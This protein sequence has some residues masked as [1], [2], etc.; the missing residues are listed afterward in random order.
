MGFFIGC[1]IVLKQ[2]DQYVLV[3]EVRG[4]KAGLYNLPAGT[5][6]LHEDFIECI[7]REAKEETGAD[8]TLEHFVGLYQTVIATGSNVVFAVF[9]GSVADD[10]I[11]QSDEHS[12]IQAFSYQEI[13]E[14]NTAGKLRAPT[15][16]KAVNDYRAGQKFPLELVQ[17]WH[18]ETFNS[19]TVEKDG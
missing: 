15:V 10:A 16:L 5:L 8:V 19:I 1:G 11:F 14:L 12:V 4:G 3:K 2:G 9:A 6:E 7:T 13:V 17:A 18:T